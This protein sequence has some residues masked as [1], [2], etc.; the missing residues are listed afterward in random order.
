MAIDLNCDLGEGAG[1]DVELMPLVTS[2]NIACGAH[3]GDETT[4]RA[5]VGLAMEHG[6]AIGA[7]PGFPDREQFGR[8][9]RAVSPEQIG[10]W[11]REQTQALIALAQEAGARVSHVKPHGAL[12]NMAARDFV[13]AEAVAAAVKACDERLVLVGLAGSELPAAGQ[14]AGLRVAHEVFA[15]RAYHRDG[16]LVARADPDALIADAVMAAQ[17]MVEL[18]RTGKVRSVD[19]CEVVLPADTICVHGDGGNAVHFAREL[20]RALIAARMRLGPLLV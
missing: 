19:G 20:R 15:D 11:V 7:H 18:L 4:M 17:R 14:R 8:R 16:T 3:A 6:V 2:A 13:M 1:H 10:D 12:Y 5:T 9:E